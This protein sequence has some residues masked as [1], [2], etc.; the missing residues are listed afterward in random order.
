MDHFPAQGPLQERDG[1]WGSTSSGLSDAPNLLHFRA[2]E[3]SPVEGR[4]ELSPMML[5]KPIQMELK[6]SDAREKQILSLSAGSAITKYHAQNGSNN[7]H[8]FLAAL[9]AGKSKSM[10]LADSVFDESILSDLQMSALMLCPHMA[11]VEGERERGG[12]TERQRDRD[13][14][15]SKLSGFWLRED[16]S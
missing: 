14:E 15:S 7:N 4:M 2:S 8:L 3:N 13:G 10:V 11:V 1:S 9:E 5:R 16:C 6:L 12:E